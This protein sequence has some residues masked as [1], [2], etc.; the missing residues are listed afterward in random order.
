MKGPAPE[1]EEAPQRS[2]APPARGGHSEKTAT[3]EPRRALTDPGSAGTVTLDI[4]SAQTEECFWCLE[5][6]RSMVFLCNSPDGLRCW[7]TAENAKKR[8]GFS[9]LS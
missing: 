6:H 1:E 2:P 7:S 5:A 9:C 4:P 8:R 3:C